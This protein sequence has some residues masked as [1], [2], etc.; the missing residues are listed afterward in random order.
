MQMHNDY[1]PLRFAAGSLL[2]FSGRRAAVLLQD[3]GFRESCCGSAAWHSIAL[4]SGDR[5]GVGTQYRSDLPSS[6]SV[7]IRCLGKLPS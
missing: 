2:P 6:C 4:P 3:Y 5:S 1:N 7:S